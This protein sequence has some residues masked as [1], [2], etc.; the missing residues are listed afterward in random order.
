M[1]DTDTTIDDPELFV[2]VEIGNNAGSYSANIHDIENRDGDEDSGEEAPEISGLSVLD[3]DDKEENVE[4]DGKEGDGRPASP[5]PGR[6]G[7][8]LEDDDKKNKH[9]F[10][11]VT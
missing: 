8:N 6:A 3:Y 2:L 4:E 1:K 5:P 10:F 11:L 7:D 9:I